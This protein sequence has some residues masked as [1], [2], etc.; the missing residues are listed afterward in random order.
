MPKARR[1]KTREPGTGTDSGFSLLELLVVASILVATSVIAAATF[2][3]IRRHTDGRLA[4]AEMQEIAAAIRRF[5]QDTGYYPKT[6]PFDLETNG[7]NV[8]LAALPSYAG[9]TDAEKEAWFYSPANFWQLIT[10][11]S[12]LIDPGSEEG[13]HP[14]AKWAPATGRGWRGPYLSGHR[15]G[16]LTIGAGVNS[17]APSPAQGERTGD[18]G[19]GD[20]IHDV[21]GIADPFEHSGVGGFLEWSSREWGGRGEGAAPPASH[22]VWGRPYLVFGWD[23]AHPTL[24]SMGPNGDYEYGDGD[25]IELEI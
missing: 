12:P 1:F 24:V 16:Y 19:A 11:Q 9:T 10:T 25:D 22:P 21:A 15:D 20:K 17:S 4:H 8:P 5:K 13:G 14:L 6:G 18:P 23:A 3:G 2:G 7:G